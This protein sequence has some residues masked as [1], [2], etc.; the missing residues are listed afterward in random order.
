M[1]KSHNF[2]QYDTARRF[3]KFEYLGENETKNETIFTHWPRPGRMM[4]KSGG[5]KSRWTVLLSQFT[6]WLC[7]STPVPVE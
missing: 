1:E 4:K 7:I 5:R 2:V 6:I 3:E